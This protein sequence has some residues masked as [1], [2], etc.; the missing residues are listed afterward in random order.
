MSTPCPARYVQ[1]SYEFTSITTCNILTK[2]FLL[3]IM[4][5]FQMK[6]T[7]NLSLVFYNQFERGPLLLLKRTDNKYPCMV[8]N[9]KIHSSVCSDIQKQTKY[10]T[11]WVVISI[12]FI[13]EN[14]LKFFCSVFFL[15]HSSS[16][17]CR[18]C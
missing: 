14:F 10:R 18:L 6:P 17:A 1:V 2:T 8:I 7:R 12:Q 16:L 13:V 3:S 4:A 11:N 5:L 9:R 15:Y